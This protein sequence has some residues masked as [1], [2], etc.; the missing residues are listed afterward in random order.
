MNCPKS[1]N[2]K[3]KEEADDDEMINDLFIIRS[4]E[5]C[6]DCDDNENFPE[7][8]ERAV[9]GATKSE[10]DGN[11]D[12]NN[13]GNNDGKS[14]DN[15]DDFSTAESV[16]ASGEVTTLTYAQAL[17]QPANRK[18]R[19]ADIDADTNDS[20]YK[21]S[22]SLQEQVNT[23]KARSL[24]KWLGD[25]SATVHC[26]AFSTGVVCSDKLK[27]KQTVIIGNGEKVEIKDAGTL[28]LM[29]ENEDDCVILDNIKV[30]PNITKNI[31]KNITSIGA[32]LKDG[33][34]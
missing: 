30:V 28:I 13:D 24:E 6:V 15:N 33:E 18:K 1:G 7:I 2:G 10:N 21:V 9:K 12:E 27:P 34:R 29:P 11:N 14:F 23:I 26:T 19:W 31:T 8:T 5:M 16:E 25:T 20:L 17:I 32:L 3:R 4:I 22:E